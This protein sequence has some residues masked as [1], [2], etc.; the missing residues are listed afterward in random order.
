MKIAFDIYYCVR[1]N[2]A[3][4]KGVHVS[5]KGEQCNAVIGEQR[6]TSKRSSGKC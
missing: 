5:Q 4:L 6:I 3:W 2:N 1:H